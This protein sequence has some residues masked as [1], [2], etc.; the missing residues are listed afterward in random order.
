MIAG[1]KLLTRFMDAPQIGPANIASNNTILP[2]A[3][4]AKAPVSFETCEVNK[5]VSIRINVSTIFK[6]IAGLN[7]QE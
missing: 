7:L 6:M 1:D 5:M 4:P 3:S 2:I